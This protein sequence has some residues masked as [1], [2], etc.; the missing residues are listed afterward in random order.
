MG[1]HLEIPYFGPRQ[2]PGGRLIPPNPTNITHQIPTN[3]EEADKYA[4]GAKLTREDMDKLWSTEDILG[5]D[6][7]YLLV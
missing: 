2:E 6:K 5:R 1:R 7:R 4:V 3:L